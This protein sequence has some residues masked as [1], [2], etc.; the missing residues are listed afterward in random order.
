MSLRPGFSCEVGQS[1][2]QF[3]HPCRGIN[4]QLMNAAETEGH[5]L[6]QGSCRQVT[7]A[8]RKVWAVLLLSSSPVGFSLGFNR[9]KTVGQAACFHYHHLTLCK[10]TVCPLLR[11]RQNG[12]PA[13]AL[14]TQLARLPKCAPRRQMEAKGLSTHSAEYISHFRYHNGAGTL[15]NLITERQ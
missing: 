8:Q 4:C 3:S 13:F 12:R 6:D 7:V 1:P 5:S 10:S 11:Q 2:P 15:L 9:N 14:L